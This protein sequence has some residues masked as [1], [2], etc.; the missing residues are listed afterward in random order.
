VCDVS[1]CDVS[2]CD[3]AVRIFGVYVFGVLSLVFPY[4]DMSSP[5]HARILDRDS[6]FMTN[7]IYIPECKA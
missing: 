1:V 7:F 5:F 6:R 3:V 4:G 2:V